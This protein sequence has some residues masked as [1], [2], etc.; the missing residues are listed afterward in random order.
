MPILVLQDPEVGLRRDMTEV[1]AK[2]VKFPV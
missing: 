1:T 2:F